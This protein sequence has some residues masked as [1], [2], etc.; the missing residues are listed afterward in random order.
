[1][2]REKVGDIDLS[3]AMGFDD[4]DIKK[5]VPY[6][7]IFAHIREYHLDPVYKKPLID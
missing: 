3:N 7:K 4:F 1:L 2:H 6:H 5:I